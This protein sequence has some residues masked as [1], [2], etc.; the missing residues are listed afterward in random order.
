[1]PP[2]RSKRLR[3]PSKKAVEV[4]AAND[5]GGS[6]KRSKRTHPQ[7]S[8]DGAGT[9]SSPDPQLPG[10]PPGVMDELVTRVAAEVTRRLSPPDTGHQP[11]VVPSALSEVPIGAV[12]S[13][14]PQS[15]SDPA[16]AAIQSSLTAA[17]SALTG[18]L[19]VVQS[20]QP[21]HMFISPSLPVDARVSGLRTERSLI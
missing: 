5:P 9:S 13:D 18:E 3:A 16:D 20:A 17:Q 14:N 7:P 12:Q 15:T 2:K 6:R 4:A 10:F 11:L 1:M 21:S 8:T 19:Q